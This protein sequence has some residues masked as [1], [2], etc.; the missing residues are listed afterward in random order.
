MAFPE[1]KFRDKKTD[2]DGD[3]YVKSMGTDGTNDV[4]IKTDAV[5]KIIL[6][7]DANISVDAYGS[8]SVK[9]KTSTAGEIITDPIKDVDVTITRDASGLVST[10]ASTYDGRV[11]T[12]TFTRD[13]NGQLTSIA[14]VIT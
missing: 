7:P 2:A 12:Q 9:I 3:Q 6:S 14:S 4:Q 5:G 1:Q 13:T 8:E 11:N 10:V